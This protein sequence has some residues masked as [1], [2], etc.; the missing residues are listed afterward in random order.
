[1]LGTKNGPR[2]FLV[3]V[4]TQCINDRTRKIWLEDTRAA[5]LAN[6]LCRLGDC[7]VASSALAVLYFARCGQS[8]SL[9]GRLVSFLFG[10]WVTTAIKS[11]FSVVF[12]GDGPLLDT[13]LQR[14]PAPGEPTSA[15]SR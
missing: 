6:L 3:A 7:Q 5:H 13:N 12:Q 9:L 4:S 14:L 10:H 1:M 11:S 15:T 8:E 2:C